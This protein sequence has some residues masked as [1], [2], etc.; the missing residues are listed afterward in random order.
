VEGGFFVTTNRSGNTQDYVALGATTPRVGAP[1]PIAW[2]EID[3]AANR[4]WAVVL[5]IWSL[6]VSGD[7]GATFRPVAEN[8]SMVAAARS[9]LQRLYATRAFYFPDRQSIVIK[10]DD[11][12]VTRKRK[13]L[14]GLDA[15]RSW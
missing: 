3:R 11:G 12:G 8:V 7:R 15:C 6:H 9:R 13:Y 14:A 10:S 4:V 1:G 2:I 5:G